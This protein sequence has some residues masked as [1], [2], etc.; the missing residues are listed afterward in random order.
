MLNLATSWILKASGVGSA[1]AT[2]EANTPT[3]TNTVQTV[4]MTGRC[5]SDSIVQNGVRC[6][7]GHNA[8]G[9][10]GAQTATAT[11]VLNRTDTV[12]VCSATWTFPRLP[13]AYNVTCYVQ[14][15]GETVGTWLGFYR[16]SDGSAGPWKATGT[17]SIPALPVTSG[18][19][20]TNCSAIRSSDSKVSVSWSNG[21][22]VFDD[23]TN[24]VERQIDGGSWTQ[25]ASLKGSTTSYSDTS[26][27]ANHRYAYRVRGGWSSGYTSWA[28]SST[29]YT[30]PAAHSAFS[31]TRNTDTNI[32]LKW[33]SGAN[34]SNVKTTYIERSVDGGSY[35]Q[36]TTVSGTATSYTDSATSTN[37]RYQYRIRSGWASLYSAYVSSQITYTTPA[38]HTS[39]TV[40]RNSDTNQSI[41]W[42]PGASPSSVKTTYIERS[43]DGGSFSQIATATGTATSYSDSSTAANHS[44]TYR[45][46]SGWGSVYSAYAQSGTSYNT[47]AAPGRPTAI[48]IDASTVAISFAN[49]GITQTATTLQRSVDGST[50]TTVASIAGTSVQSATD[51]PGGGTWYYRVGNTRDNLISPWSVTSAPVVTMQPP[52][53]P[54]LKS[55]ASSMVIS[56]SEEDITFEWTHNTKDGSA[57][58]AAEIQYS[59]DGG[60]SYVD[61]GIVGSAAIYAL[62]NTFPVNTQ[63]TWRVKTK[64]ADPGFGNYSSP[65]TFSIYQNPLVVITSPTGEIKDLPLLVEWSY[66]DPSGSQQQ[67]SVELI[68]QEGRTLYSCSVQGE[69]TSL[70]I[71]SSDYLP[72]N[73]KTYRL[74]VSVRSTTSLTSQSLLDIHTSYHEPALPEASLLIGPQE[75]LVELAVFMGD[76]ALAPPTVDMGILRRRKDGTYLVLADHVAPGTATTDLYPPL[77]ETLTYVFVAYAATGVASFVEMTADIPSH[78]SSYINYGDGFSKVSKLVLDGEWDM[79]QEHTRELFETAGTHQKDRYP[80]VDYGSGV[81]RIGAIRATALRDEGA[82][83]DGLSHHLIS[84]IEDASC[85]TGTVILRLPFEEPFAADITVSQSFANKSLSSVVIEYERVRAHGLAI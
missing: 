41:S 77:D 15:S 56:T 19:A 73:N 62:A 65:R 33:T 67:A 71:S 9:G 48:R 61:V 26:V 70:H 17:V 31:A 16:G 46:R 6:T 36:I 1:R 82:L 57:Q 32:A 25:I 22:N 4:T 55:P 63:V 54:T 29:V 38:A 47:P 39:C 44:Y 64:G 78:M 14:F 40:T 74:V 68:S 30:T 42:S 79:R 21:A 51:S 20:P 49:T 52:D 85:W 80:V 75:A 43:V 3:Q 24:Y 72:E 76:D 27:A 37:H 53:A 12:A 5:T 60:K 13:K 2:A 81:R 58:S 45:V 35:S 7:I 34:P 11:G 84:D 28:T 66:N 83:Y 69:Q 59:V 23:K 50:W 18:D 10:V 8:A